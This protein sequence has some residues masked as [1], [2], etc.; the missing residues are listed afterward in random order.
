[1]RWIVL[2]AVAL[3]LAG[4]AAFAE[5]MEHRAPMHGG[6]PM[7]GAMPMQCTACQAG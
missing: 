2:T 7:Q 5:G 6:M 1:M 4:A 3:A